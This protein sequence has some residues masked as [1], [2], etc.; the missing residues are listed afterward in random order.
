VT[1]IASLAHPS[2]SFELRISSGQLQGDRLRQEDAFITL[3]RARYTIAL[4]ADGLG[5]HH[6]GDEA[7]RVAINTVATHIASSLRKL[8]RDPNDI[9]RKAFMLGHEAVLSYQPPDSGRGQ[10]DPATTMVGGVFF[11]DQRLFYAAN[12]GDSLSFLLRDKILRRIFSPH[13]S[14][15]GIGCALGFEIGH[16]GSRISLLDF[17]LELR[18][19]DR[20]LLASDGLAGLSE[21]ILA[22]H[23]SADTARQACE[24]L[25]REISDHLEPNQDNVTLVVA[26]TEEWHFRSMP[27]GS[28]GQFRSDDPRFS[29]TTEPK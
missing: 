12:A 22:R 26:F 19:G 9:L 10:L 29:E 4:V 2:P 18:P 3:I 11:L 20:I 15:D 7:S 25:L 17:P 16:Q 24:G 8:D 27:D 14:D 6:A 28:F 5:G 23:L 13:G 1:S 21:E